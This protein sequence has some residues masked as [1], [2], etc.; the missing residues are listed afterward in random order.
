MTQKGQWTN[1]TIA[2]MKYEKEENGKKLKK[3]PSNQTV[4]EG[5][6]KGN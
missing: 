5:A 4:T 3:G 2:S 6:D 1:K